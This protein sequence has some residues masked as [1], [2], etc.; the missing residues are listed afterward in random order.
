MLIIISPYCE[1]EDK[2]WYGM[3]QFID[4]LRENFYLIGSENER[5]LFGYPDNVHNLMG[6]TT[7]AQAIRMI[8]N[9][10]I[11][12]SNDTGFYHLATRESVKTIAIFTRTK[13]F[14]KA[15]HLNTPTTRVMY[16]PTVHEVEYMKN[17]M[18]YSIP[19]DLCTPTE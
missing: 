10:D 8:K 18:L 17:S 11:Y 14:F 16:N 3:R 9:A 5:K 13:Y 6:E 4:G 2:N 19:Y 15:A 1:F 7:Q 12:I